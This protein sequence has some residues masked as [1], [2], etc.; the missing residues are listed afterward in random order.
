MSKFRD[1][2]DEMRQKQ[3]RKDDPIIKISLMVRSPSSHDI[4]ML[5]NK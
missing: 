2:V 5:E 1:D 3:N 4:L